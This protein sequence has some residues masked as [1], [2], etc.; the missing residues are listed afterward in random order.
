MSL[1]A[2]GSWKKWPKRSALPQGNIRRPR[3]NSILQRPLFSAAC[4]WYRCYPIF[5]W[6]YPDIDVRLTLSDRLVN[7]TEEGID[8]ALRVGDLPDSALIATRIATV[9]RVFAASPKY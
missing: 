9:H 6:A 3:A 8:A 5:F 2:S 4:I 1:P 7:L